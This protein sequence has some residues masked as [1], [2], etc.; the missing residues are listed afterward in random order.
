[1][2]DPRTTYEPIGYE[3][4][5]P[6]QPEGLAYLFSEGKIRL[7]DWLPDFEDDANELVYLVLTATHSQA[8]KHAQSMLDKAE[9]LWE[10]R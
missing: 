5:D 2:S 7:S 8:E 1:M 3:S 10:E 4:A 9:R 6:P